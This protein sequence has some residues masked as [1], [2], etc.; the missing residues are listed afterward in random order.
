[1]TDTFNLMT[2]DVPVEESE[3]PDQFEALA[4]RLGLERLASKMKIGLERIIERRRRSQVTSYLA[5]S[6]HSS[7][8]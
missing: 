6:A 2:A 7:H 4:A 8:R 3:R 5:C 1:M